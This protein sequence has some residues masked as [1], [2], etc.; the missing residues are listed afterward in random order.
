MITRT[1]KASSQAKAA[2][3]MTADGAPPGHVMGGQSWS[4]GGRTCSA[5]GFVILGV[6][7]LLVG[8]LLPP[9]WL[10]AIICLVIGLVSGRG[11][12]EL[13][14]TWMPAP[15]PMTPPEDDDGA[16]GHS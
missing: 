2:Q 14:V 11:D 9:L 8:L 13:T 1:Y 3:K 4:P 15:T 5:Q 12:G 6:L 16:S 7:L 10:L